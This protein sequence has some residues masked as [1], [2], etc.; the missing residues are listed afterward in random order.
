[1]ALCVF[2]A[3]AQQDTSGKLP[4]EILPSNGTR[5]E[6]IT[7]DSGAINKL[8]NNVALKQGDNYMYC[9]SAY[10]DLAKNNVYAFGNVRLIQNSGTQVQSDYLRYTGNTKR[11]YL[12]GNV[13]LTDGK[14]NL[15]S[16]EL[17]YNLNTKLGV[18]T[19]GGTLQS[20]M[21]TLSS[22]AGTY[23]AKTK[24]ARFTGDVFVTDPEY[25]VTSV[26]LGYNTE[27]K[28]VRFLGAS[29]VVNDK[30]TLHTSS[31][32]WDAKN[33]I[34]HFTTRSSIQNEAQYI[35]GDKMDYNRKTGFGIVVGNVFALDTSQKA[36][37]YSGHAQYNEITRQLWAT[38]KPVMKRVNGDD[39]LY[40]RADT[41]YAAPVPRAEDSLQRKN[42]KVKSKKEIGKNVVETTEVNVTD[43]TASDSS[44][45]R[46]FIGYHHVLVY[47]DSLQA[48]C[49]SISY[50]QADSTMRLMY[51][52]IAWSRKSQ[53][54]GDTILLYT[55]SNTLRKLFVPNNAFVVS[56]SG[57]EKANMYDQVQGKTLTGFFENNAIKTMLVFPNAEAIYYSKD[58]ADAYLGMNQA[59]SERMRVFFDSSQVSKIVLEQDVKQTMTPMQQVNIATA[60]L[61]RFQWHA[62]KRPKSVQELFLYEPEGVIIPKEEGKTDREEEAPK[63]KSNRKRRK[64]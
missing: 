47:S 11:A 36:T 4:I 50:S 7:T 6:Y 35:E 21:T 22:N 13:S 64:R 26:D 60:I 15:W 2:K 59:T 29:V 33:E 49:D 53:I 46:Y 41:F 42:E 17:E 58:E 16:E 44:R 18:Y 32:T 10:I 28:V 9:D 14:N 37:L 52:P 57:P 54:T 31:G 34:A 19:Q 40:I 8:I 20:E 45:P 30:S 27:T 1:M 61:A 55:D 56:Q 48:R 24:D 39:S 25:N 5:L 51:N 38:I 63:Q 62:E 3:N 23:N 43:T 12:K